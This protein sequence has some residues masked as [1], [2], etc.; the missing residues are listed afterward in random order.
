MRSENHFQYA[1]SSLD[2]EVILL[3]ASM[4]DFS[5]GMHAHEE[6]S[7]GVTL[8]GRQD[9]FALGEHHKSHPSNTIVFN[10]DDAH[11]GHSGGDDTLHYK[12]LYI[13]PDQ[14]TPMLKNAGLSNPHQF[15]MKQCVHEDPILRQHILR[16]ALLVEN[17][18]TSELQYSS[19][20]FEF[21][22]Y[23]TAQTGTQIES[24]NTRKDFIFERVRDYLH[25]HVTEE[26]SL[27]EVRGK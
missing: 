11:D 12:M 24:K 15:R 3:D 10:P 19:A 5:Y 9:F 2:N 1:K 18:H 16:L 22:R 4:N 26:V 17:K 6:F 7:F 13:H 25:S 23:L 14:L 21:A 27:D 20:L 8:A